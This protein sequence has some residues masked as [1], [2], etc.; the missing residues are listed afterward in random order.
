MV[1]SISREQGVN[2]IFKHTK[3]IS[4]QSSQNGHHSTTQDCCI[5]TALR[6]AYVIVQGRCSCSQWFEPG[7]LSPLGRTCRWQLRGRSLWPQTMIPLPLPPAHEAKS[8]ENNFSLHISTSK[9]IHLYTYVIL[10]LSHHRCV[11]TQ[12]D[13]EGAGC[14]QLLLVATSAEVNAPALHAV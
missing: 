4:L 1:D 3:L 14:I 12:S 10:Q 9:L 2:T 8:R 13:A 5:S 11:K 6:A 7:L